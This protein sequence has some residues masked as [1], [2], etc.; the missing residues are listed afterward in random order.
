MSLKALMASDPIAFFEL[1][2]L[3]KD[4]SHKLFGNTG[5]KLSKLGLI[6]NGTVHGSIRNIVLSAVEGEMLDMQLVSPI[7]PQET[8]ATVGA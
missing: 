3:C 5:E 8:A 1:S 4:R 2:E 6:Q 7:A